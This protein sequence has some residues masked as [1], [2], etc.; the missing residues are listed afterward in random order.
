MLSRVIHRLPAGHAL[1]LL[2]AVFLLNVSL[3][4]CAQEG[5]SWAEDLLQRVAEVDEQ[6]SGELGVFVKD[7]DSGVSASYHGDERWYLASTVKVPVAIAIMRRVDQ[8]TLSLDSTV[9]LME[10][11]YVDGAGPTNS[12]APGK[13]LSVR[14]LMDQ[15]LIHSDNT[16][17][18]MLISLVGL[19][20]VNAVT[21]E[22]VPEG[23]GPITSLADVRRLIYG[24]F[25]PAAR[26]LSGRDF[27]RLKQQRSEAGRL[28]LLAR[29]LGVPQRELRPIRLSEAYERYYATPNNSAT[30]QAYGDLLAALVAGKAVSQASTEYLLSVMTRVQTGAQ[31]IKAGLPATVNYAHKTGTQVARI[32]DAGLIAPPPFRIAEA[33]GRIVVV[34]CVRGA[35]STVKAE[36]ALRGAGEAITASGV[37]RL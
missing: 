21:A 10:S 8:G 19:E 5:F 23:F 36:R 15:M 31:R 27:L 24:E 13:R 14:Y 2:L 3:P 7:L 1:S 33:S 32:C 11:D 35:A 9:R 25:H 20:A 18:D 12:L 17:S 37:L 29:L 26:Q 34:A 22:L 30:L 4:A 28:E 6:T 16:A